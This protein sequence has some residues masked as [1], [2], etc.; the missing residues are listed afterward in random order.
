ML[1]EASPARAPSAKIDVLIVDKVYTDLGKLV[2]NI[3]TM[4]SLDEA[5]SLKG[6]FFKRDSFVKRDLVTE[7]DVEIRVLQPNVHAVAVPGP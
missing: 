2:F 3:K 1:A 7:A 4:C 5:C 6:L